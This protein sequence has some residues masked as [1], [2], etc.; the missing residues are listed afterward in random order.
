MSEKE[1]MIAGQ[2]YDASD[3]TLTREREHAHRLCRAYGREEPFDRQARETFVDGLGLVRKGD[4][5]IEAPFFCDYGYNIHCG[6]DVYMNAHCIILDCAPVEIGSRVMFGPN[7]QIYTA[8][9]PID[10]CER[11]SLREYAKPISIGDDVWLGGNVTVAPGVR[12]GARSVIGA[13]S[14][15]TKDIPSDVVAAGNPCRVIRKIS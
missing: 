2:M 15:V 7:V 14:V 5:Y 13:G 1:K 3:S 8:T 4:V 6:E 9:H 11:A 12:I 10:A